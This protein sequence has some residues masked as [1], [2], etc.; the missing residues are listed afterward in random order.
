[1]KMSTAMNCSFL[2]SDGLP[3]IYKIR[4]EKPSE[5]VILYKEIILDDIKL[6]GVYG[7]FCKYVTNNIEPVGW[8]AIW[9]C[10]W[11]DSKCLFEVS[12]IDVAHKKLEADVI[13]TQLIEPSIEELKSEERETIEKLLQGKSATVQLI[14][15]YVI[16]ENDDD[17]DY[18]ETAK[19]IEFVRFFYTNI[20]RPWDE[21]HVGTELG[22]RIFVDNCFQ[23]RIELY[24]DIKNNMIPESTA[25]KI[26]RALEEAWKIKGKLESIEQKQLKADDNGDGRDYIEEDQ[27]NELLKL[28]LRFEDIEREINL[29][30]DK[31]MRP[32]VSQ[33]KRYIDYDEQ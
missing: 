4:F 14:Q 5:L 15:L 2:P 3:S 9:R 28:K 13:I 16:S 7:E 8:T 33:M 25:N 6:D 12:V 20:W 24:F 32:V 22:N 10:P 17:E 23:Q 31:H 26:K 18:Y 27:V 21:L 30:E 11:F 29:L 19:V 1:M